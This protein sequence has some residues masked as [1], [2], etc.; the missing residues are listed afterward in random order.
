MANT[1]E[2]VSKS[3]SGLVKVVGI[4][5]LLFSIVSIIQGFYGL[6]VSF[7]EGRFGFTYERPKDKDGILITGVVKGFPAELAGL[8]RQEF[9][10][11]LARF[12]V[13][14]FQTTPAELAEELERE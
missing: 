9:L 7:R 4:F 1:R 11:N 8:S 14:P 6:K 5:L 10:Q 13:S 3:A 12:N 2:W